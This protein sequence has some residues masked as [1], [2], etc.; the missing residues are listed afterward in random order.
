MCQNTRYTA[1]QAAPHAT[2]GCKGHHHGTAIDTSAEEAPKAHQCQCSGTTSQ[3]MTVGEEV[4][5]VEASHELDFPPVPFPSRR[6][7]DTAGEA[8]LR[9]LVRRHHE[10]LR[11]GPL[12]S[13]FPI[14]D[15]VFYVGVD[16]TADY[17]VEACGGPALFARHGGPTCMRTRHFPFTIDESARETWLAE[18]W[19][20]FA[21][22][23][24]PPEIRQEYWNW[25][26]P[27]SLRMIN[28]RTQRAQ[29]LRYPFELAG[30]ALARHMTSHPTSL[31]V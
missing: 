11:A 1:P 15:Q 7:F 29:P 26:E 13:L 14:D 22:V 18:L 27:F 2:H 23:G 21:D 25:A 19:Q 10:R 28:R 30:V 20:S 3:G 5:W 17:I 4:R 9:K 24:F 6:I 31:P 12:G 16:R 8:L